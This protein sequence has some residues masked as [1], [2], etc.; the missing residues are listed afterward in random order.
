MFLPLTLEFYFDNVSIMFKYPWIF[1]LTMLAGWVNRHQQAM[2]DY[3]HEE[4]HILREKVG[5]KRIILNDDQRRR[6]AIKG[7]KLGRKLLREVCRVFEP[8]TVLKW[9]R[10]LVASKYDGSRNRRRPGR[11][12]ISR[13]IE[14]LI[15]RMARENPD[16]GYLKIEGYLKYLGYQASRTTVKRV[17]IRRGFDPDPK[18][19]KRTTWSQFIRTHWESLSAV[20]FFTVEVHTWNGLV[21]YMVLFAIDLC[22]RKVEIAGIVP[23]ADGAW[24]EQMARNLTDPIDGF[25][26]DK[27]YLIHDRDPC[28]TKK[29]VDILRSA[30]VEPKKMPKQS[31]NLNEYYS[32]CTLL[33][34]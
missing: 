26:N 19:R 22:T 24:T 20:D 14:D 21:R 11:P 10:Q 7:K 28:F 16:W 34:A 18:I 29:F 1:F 15:V 27:K 23:Q 3:L 31:P 25:L 6:L 2:I 5:K 8:D 12:P 9:H 30:G 33:V 17:L 13:E 4:N 32:N